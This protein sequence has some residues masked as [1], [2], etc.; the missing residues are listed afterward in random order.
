MNDDEPDVS[1]KSRM[2]RIFNVVCQSPRLPELEDDFNY[3]DPIIADLLDKNW[4][5]EIANR[6]GSHNIIANIEAINDILEIAASKTPEMEN[7]KGKNKEI[8]SPI[9]NQNAP[10]TT[11]EPSTKNITIMQNLEK[12][13]TSRQHEARQSDNN[14]REHT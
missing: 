8:F 5:E 4:D 12:G 11:L 6:K 14:E 1:V 10:V 13:S 3:D 9:T 7:K 2:P